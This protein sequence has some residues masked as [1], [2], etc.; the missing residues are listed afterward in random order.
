MLNSI[1]H[2]TEVNGKKI[3]VMD[4]LRKLHPEVQ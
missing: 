4:D 2:L 3:C 1:K